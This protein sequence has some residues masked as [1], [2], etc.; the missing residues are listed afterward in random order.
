[1]NW[2]KSGGVSRTVLTVCE[3]WDLACISSLDHVGDRTDRPIRRFGGQVQDD[4]TA[5]RRGHPRVASLPLFENGCWEEGR[6]RKFWR[7]RLVAAGIRREGEDKE[8]TVASDVGRAVAPYGPRQIP[9]CWGGTKMRAGELAAALS[10]KSQMR[11]DPSLPFLFPSLSLSRTTLGSLSSGARI[12]RARMR[13]RSQVRFF[14]P[15]NFVPV[16]ST[17]HPCAECHLKVGPPRPLFPPASSYYK[18][19]PCCLF[20]PELRKQILPIQ[21]INP[22]E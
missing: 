17:R 7:M 1:M 10:P 18:V 6:I 12:V 21:R 5:P 19:G 22:L 2:E 4:S 13:L 9:G 8:Q 15:L 14:P 3:S 16:I 11:R 20:F